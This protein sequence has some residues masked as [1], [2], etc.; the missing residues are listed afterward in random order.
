M[1]A[2]ADQLWTLADLEKRWQPKGATAGARRKWVRRRVAA[3]GIPHE[4]VRYE[5]RFLPSEVLKAEQRQL[6]GRQRR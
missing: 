3:W 5:P 1:S 6:G 4:A 2:I